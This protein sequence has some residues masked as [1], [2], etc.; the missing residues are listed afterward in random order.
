V[1]LTLGTVGLQFSAVSSTVQEATG[2][3]GISTSNDVWIQGFAQTGP[4]Q[5]CAVSHLYFD[6]TTP[7]NWLVY[8]GL[9]DPAGGP[10]NVNYVISFYSK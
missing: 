7:P 2:D 3:S 6:N 1:S 9:S 5:A 4:A 8:M 10:M